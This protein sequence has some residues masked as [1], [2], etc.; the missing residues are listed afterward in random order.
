MVSQEAS[1][2][3]RFFYFNI[4]LTEY[5]SERVTAK[6]RPYGIATTTIETPRIKY[7]KI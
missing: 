6:G 4:C 2:R 5:A 1:L 7:L 3:T